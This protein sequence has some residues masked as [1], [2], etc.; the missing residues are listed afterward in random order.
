MGQ[1]TL[2]NPHWEAL[3]S[4]THQAF[5]KTAG[6]PFISQF[7][8]AGGTGLALHLG[9][10]FSVDLDFFSS[11]P[12]SVGPDVRAVLREVLDDPT[13]SITHDKDTTFVVTWRGVGISFFD[14]HPYPLVQQPLLVE[15][16]SV[17][18]VAEIGA[19]K[20]AAIIGRG[21]RKDLVDLH[22]ILQQVP[23]EDLFGVAATKYARVRTFAV[24]AT[25]ALAYFEDAE[26]LPMP[27]M[28]D[29][30]P[31]TTMKRFLERQAMSA[32]RKHLADL[33]P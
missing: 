24:S 31:W 10:R 1:I 13:L 32:G 21:T 30:T 26:A 28:I 27:T 33:W 8:L 25:R 19:M 16:V 2:S 12:D 18:T 5:H 20:L 3:T 14:L 29:P 7:Y 23:I 11:A 15:G 22:Y 6:L 4:E 17:A 9:H